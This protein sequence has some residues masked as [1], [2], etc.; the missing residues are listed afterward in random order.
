MPLV[1]VVEDHGPGL[2][3]ENALVILH[4]PKVVAPLHQFLDLLARF[5]Q[6][7]LRAGDQLLHP[8]ENGVLRVRQEVC[9]EDG[10]DESLAV[11]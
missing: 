8:L 5:L 2:A 10:L 1:D 11:L 6:L 4:A 7:F 3:L 9:A